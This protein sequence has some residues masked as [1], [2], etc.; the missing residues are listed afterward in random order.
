MVASLTESLRA[1]S[2][3][4]DRVGS[5]EVAVRSP[6]LLSV[7]ALHAGRRVFGGSFHSESNRVLSVNAMLMFSFLYRV[8]PLSSVGLSGVVSTRNVAD[9]FFS[10]TKS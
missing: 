9:W 8:V 5:D 3:S 4:P 1:R 6:L 2:G 7:G 10:S